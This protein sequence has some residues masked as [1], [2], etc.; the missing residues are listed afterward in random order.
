MPPCGSKQVSLSYSMSLLFAW[1]HTCYLEGAKDFLVLFY[2]ILYFIL[3]YFLFYS[4]FS[5]ILHPDHSFPLTTFLS[6]SAPPALSPRSTPP[7]FPFRKE[8]AFKEYQPNTTYQVT[9]RLRTYLHFKAGEG[10]PE[11][12]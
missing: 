12:K 6:P 4:F 9:I 2:F 1:S 7:P 5:H 10:N 8:Q 3:F 11:G